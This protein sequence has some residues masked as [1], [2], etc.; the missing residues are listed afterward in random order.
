MQIYINM[1]TYKY[2]TCLTENDYCF[3]VI[4]IIPD[5]ISFL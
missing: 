5:E 2:Y 3:P 4:E 1:N